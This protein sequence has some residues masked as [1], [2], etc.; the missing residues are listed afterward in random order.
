MLYNKGWSSKS[1]REKMQ[2]EK[3][4]RKIQAQ[5]STSLLIE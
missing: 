1:A 5:V 2:R 3:K 4:Y